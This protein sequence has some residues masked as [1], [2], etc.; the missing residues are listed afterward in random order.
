[1]C[2]INRWARLGDLFTAGGGGGWGLWGLRGEEQRASQTPRSSKGPDLAVEMDGAKFG[3]DTVRL[4]Q[5]DFSLSKSL[6][7][8]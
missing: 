1:M 3:K 6:A 8:R 7:Y 2:I 4:H 5:A